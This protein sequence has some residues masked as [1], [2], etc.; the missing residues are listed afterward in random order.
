MVSTECART[1]DTRSNGHLSRVNSPFWLQ[2]PP[3][4]PHGKKKC[5]FAQKRTENHHPRHPQQRHISGVEASF[6]GVSSGRVCLAAPCRTTVTALAISE[7]HRMQR[8]AIHFFLQL[9]SALRVVADTFGHA[10]PRQ[11]LFQHTFSICFWPCV[12]SME[13]FY[14]LMRFD[15]YN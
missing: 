14:L 1:A 4:P 5:T 12:P 11:L 6:F 8:K 10:T 3:L 2:T 7:F 9:S 13:L 15:I